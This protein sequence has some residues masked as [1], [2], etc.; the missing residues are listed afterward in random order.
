[1]AGLELQVVIIRMGTEAKLLDLHGVL[2][3]LGLFFLLLLF[4]HEFAEVDN[5]TDRRPGFR[6]HFYKI[7]AVGFGNAKGLFNRDDLMF[8]VRLDYTDLLGPDFIINIRFIRI[9]VASRWS[10]S[11]DGFLSLFI[12]V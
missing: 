6:R 10:S 11:C 5:L 7:E 4:V 8:F 2:L 9:D 1:M 12:G 3:F